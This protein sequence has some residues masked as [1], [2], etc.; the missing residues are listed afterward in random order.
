MSHLQRAIEE[1]ISTLRSLSA[2]EE[3]LQQA[4]QLLEPKVQFVTLE[5]SVLKTETDV[6]AWLA[7]Q[8]DR[9]LNTLTNGPVQ[10][11]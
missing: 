1:S 2:L 9:L 3:P 6:D 4:A 8:R 5:R 10:I 11:Q 7:R